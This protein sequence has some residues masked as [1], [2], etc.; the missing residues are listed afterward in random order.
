MQVS[1][2]SSSVLYKYIFRNACRFFVMCTY[3]YFKNKTNP[4]NELDMY[5]ISQHAFDCE[6]VVAKARWHI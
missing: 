5:L 1:T 4:R 6:M 3:T 2:W